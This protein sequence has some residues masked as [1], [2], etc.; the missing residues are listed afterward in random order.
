LNKNSMRLILLGILLLL[1]VSLRMV[2]TSANLQSVP[3]WEQGDQ[4]GV[5]QVLAT[6]TAQAVLAQGFTLPTDT[7]ESPE[8]FPENQIVTDR[9]TSTFTPGPGTSGSSADASRAEVFLAPKAAHERTVLPGQAGLPVRI[10]VPS[11]GIDAPVIASKSRKILIHADVFEQWI[12]PEKFAA[13]WITASALLGEIGNTVIS[14]HHNDYG[15]VFGR[16]VNVNVGDS[17]LVFSDDKIYGYK[18]TNRMILQEV[19]VPDNTRIQNAQWIGRSVDE[20]L[21]LVTCWPADSN[22][23]RLILVAIPD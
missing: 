18:V 10:L 17:I 3:D 13:G 12:A 2:T 20:R 8:T 1:L 9:V 19:D 14:G 16:L 15:E 4:E 6:T 23:H 11:V 5:A 22:T 21:T 7:S